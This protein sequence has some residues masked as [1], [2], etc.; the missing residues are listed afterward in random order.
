MILAGDVGG[1]KT[2]LA[3]YEESGSRLLARRER[4]FGSGEFASLEEIVAAFLAEPARI[5]ACCVGVAGPVFDGVCRTTNLP[6]TVSEASLAAASGAP[7]AT[8]LNDLQATAYGMLFL[9]PEELCALHAPA[10]AARPGSIAVIAPGTGLGEAILCRDGER[11]LPM[12]SEGG[13]C[14]FAPRNALEIDLLRHM[15]E[16][17]GGHVSYERILSGAGLH[18]IYSFLRARAAEPEPVWLSERLGRHD[19][20]AVIGGAGLAGTNP[21]CAAAVDLFVSILGAEAGNLALKCLAVG[22]VFVG[23]GIAPKLLLA[24]QRGGFIE[25]FADKG[26]FADLL[27]GIPVWVA[28]NPKAALLGAAHFARA[29]GGTSALASPADSKAS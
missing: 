2:I 26:R 11:Y 27:R 16:R 3:L 17:I 10:A 14:D 13:H 21:T 6:W 20:A 28:R 22:G 15:A 29:G 24:V 7:R 5:G 18:A 1:T 4:E 25:A 19:P 23:G 8:L 12:A 9:R